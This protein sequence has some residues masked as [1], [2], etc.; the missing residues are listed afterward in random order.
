MRGKLVILVLM[1]LVL[2]CGVS[3]AVGRL[4][5]SGQQL[6]EKMKAGKV[7]DIYL[8]DAGITGMD[9]NEYNVPSNEFLVPGAFEEI[10]ER[11]MALAK[12]HNVKV[13]PSQLSKKVDRRALLP[14][15]LWIFNVVVLLSILA[16]VINI[17]KRVANIEK[18]IK[19]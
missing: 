19:K 5:I 12:E 13:L 16:T 4:I 11:F 3:H 15:I 18:L 6:E 8:T 9:T 17:N 2:T 7:L 14:M 10:P 1:Q